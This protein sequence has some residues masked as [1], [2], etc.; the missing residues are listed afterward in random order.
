MKTKVKWTDLKSE[1]GI[2][3]VEK[4]TINETDSQISFNTYYDFSNKDAL[5]FLHKNH[6]DSIHR[7]CKIV[8]RGDKYLLKQYNL[9]KF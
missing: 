4:E 3:L 8:K 6:K 7:H 2:Q 5:W 9:I 1:L